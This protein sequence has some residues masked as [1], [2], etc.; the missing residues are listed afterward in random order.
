MDGGLG[1][2]LL[3]DAQ[4]GV[5]DGRGGAPVLVDLETEGSAAQLGV[6]ALAGH[7]VAL[8]E[9]PDVDRVGLQRREHPGQVPGPGRDGGGLGAFGRSGAAADQGGDPGGER[10][11]D[12][13]GGDE[14]HVGVDGAGGD[15][16]PVARDDLGLGTDDQRGV[17][18]V[19]GVG[20]AGLADAADPAVAD[21]EVGLDDAP[22]VEDDDPGDHGVRS[23]LGPGGAGLPHGLA[24]HLAAAEDG[25]VAGPAGAAAEVLLDLDEEVGVREPDPVAGRRP[26]EVGVHR[27]GDLSHRAALPSPRAARVRCAGRPAERVPPRPGCR[28]RSGRP[29]RRR[30]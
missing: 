27:A 8:A 18:P 22:V 17:D 19:H 29:Y 30:R 13:R 5:D 12:D 9:Q 25:L 24:D 11:L 23:A 15:D 16:L 6:H 21:A 28:A 3:A 14:V 7:G 4:A 1:A 2:G 10:L 20:V 26:E